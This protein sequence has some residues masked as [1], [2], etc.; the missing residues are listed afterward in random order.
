MSMRRDF[1]ELLNGCDEYYDM[2]RE[3]VNDAWTGNNP[4]RIADFTVKIEEQF[5]GEGQ[6]DT[7][8]VVFSL[9][10]DGE[11]KYFKLD[12]WYASYN[13][14]EFEDFYDFYEVK[15]VEKVVKVWE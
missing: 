9:E 3:Y 14:H 7:Y 4:L 2:Y 11:K 5:G 6:G 8:W 10:R 1:V 15:Q 12:G 13:G